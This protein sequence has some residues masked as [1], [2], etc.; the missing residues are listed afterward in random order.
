MKRLAQKTLTLAAV[1]TA[2]AGTVV[3]PAA[4]A[5]A[6]RQLP[7]YKVAA[8]C[9]W[10]EPSGGGEQRLLFREGA[11]IRP[12]VRSA[13]NQTFETWCFY[14]QPFYAGYRRREIQSH[15][16]V[17]DFGFTAYSARPGNCY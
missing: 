13:Q 8:V 2:A 1:V 4:G 17:Y 16:T 14:E 5:H 3:L 15:E 12:A 11:I 7:C 6:D 10:T 9:M